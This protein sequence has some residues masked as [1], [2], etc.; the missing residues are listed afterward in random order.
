MRTDHIWMD[1]HQWKRRRD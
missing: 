1:K